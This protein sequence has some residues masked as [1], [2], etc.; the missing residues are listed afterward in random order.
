MSVDPERLPEELSAAD[1]GVEADLWIF[2]G[3]DRYRPISMVGQGG[4]GRVYRVLDSTLGREVAL[5]LIRDDRRELGD[6]LIREARFQSQ[7]THPHVCP[8]HD[9][10]VR[11]GRAFIAMKY[12]DGPTLATAAPAL[13]LQEKLGLS[14][15]VTEAV[16]AA[17]QAGLIHRDIKP[18]NVLLERTDSGSW[19]PYVTDFGLARDASAT[20]LTSSGVIAGTPH[21]LAPEQLVDSAPVADPRVDVYALGVTMYE[22][23]GGRLPFDGETTADLLIRIATQE[24]RPLRRISPSAPPDLETIVGKCLEKDPA[25]RYGSARAVADDLDRLMRGEPVTARPSSWTTRMVRRARRHR[26]V[27][28]L[29]ALSLVLAAGLAVQVV[30]AEQRA[31]SQQR[32]AAELNEELTYVQELLRHSHTSPLHD[33]RDEQQRIRSRVEQLRG[34]VERAGPLAHGPGYYALGRAHLG[35]RDYD[36]ARADLERSWQSGYRHPEVAHALGRTWGILYQEEIER[37][38]RIP[39]P[40]VRSELRIRIDQ[41][42]RQPALEFL[43]RSRDARAHS[44]ALLEALIAFYDRRYEESLDQIGEA[45]RDFPWEYEAHALEARIRTLTGNALRDSGD[46]LAADEEHGRAEGAYRAALSIGRSDPSLHEGLCALWNE[47]A[48]LYAH[49]GSEPHA[50]VMNAVSA[51]DDALIAD[52]DSTMP[53]IR[54]AEAFIQLG[55]HE[56]ARGNDSSAAFARATDLA[57]LVVETDSSNALGHYYLGLT[58]WWDAVE[59]F[60]RRS[61]PRPAL[62]IAISMFERSLSLDPGFTFVRGDLGSAHLLWSDYAWRHGGDANPQLQ[63]AIDQLAHVVTRAPSSTAYHNLGYALIHRGRLESLRRDD[64]SRTYERSVEAF[65]RAI[66]SNPKV[67]FSHDGLA[68]ALLRLAEHRLEGGNDPSPLLRRAEASLDTAEVLLPGYWETS[69]LRGLLRLTRARWLAGNGGGAA[70]ELSEAEAVLLRARELNPAE[71][72]TAREMA[73]VHLLRAEIA[74]ESG[75]EIFS[76]LRW[77]D[78]AVADEPHD[79]ENL[80]M[81][82]I[83]R[84]RL[85]ADGADRSMV[86]EG[87]RLLESALDVNCNLEPLIVPWL[88]A[89]PAPAVRRVAKFEVAGR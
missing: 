32:L 17:H 45:L 21:Y 42:F 25:R 24:P 51:C 70:D 50:A 79:A 35:L 33:V 23:F 19:W 4:M 41:T 84:I 36:R 18:S 59:T 28:T 27:S 67:P 30:R 65:E 43:H 26:T 10:G 40:N 22:L 57:R 61:D 54:K 49:L 53:L 16:H 56:Q 34:R 73:N 12:V 11:R 48:R 60:R 86:A 37:N 9:A 7:V 74:A 72:W 62:E 89:A 6:R 68:T 31:R 76:A 44:P 13:T 78:Q 69:F 83:V 1:S 63:K 14:R 5:K 77:A 39:D 75:A 87:Y 2:H 55:A 8:I 46:Y 15:A 20:H 82:G 81:A 80:R 58:H 3:W 52:P 47:R 64:P 85:G 71:S 38:E 29:V 88:D 66:A